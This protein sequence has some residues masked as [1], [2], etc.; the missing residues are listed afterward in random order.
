MG[1]YLD[2][3]IRGCFGIRHGAG[4]FHD[5][6]SFD[7]HMALESPPSDTAYSVSRLERLLQRRPDP[8]HF[9]SELLADTIGMDTIEGG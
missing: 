4:H 8:R 3:W 2:K 7:A 9:S 1:R 5:T 6:R